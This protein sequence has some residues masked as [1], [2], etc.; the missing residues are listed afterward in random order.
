MISYLKQLQPKV[1][2]SFCIGIFVLI[3]ITIIS[4]LTFV[5]PKVVSASPAKD[6]ADVQLA[7]KIEIKFNL[8]ISRTSITP[9]I[10]PDVEGSWQYT[11][12]ILE[13]HLFNTLVF[14]PTAHFNPATKYT[15]TIGNISPVYG[16]KDRSYS[17]DFT[18][19]TVPVIAATSIVNNSENI[20]IDTPIT[21]DLSEANSGLVD[22]EFSIEPPIEFSVIK[23]EKGYTIKPAS[24]LAAKTIYKLTAM[25]IYNISGVTD[26]GEKDFELNFKTAAAK[27]TTVSAPKPV[28]IAV[29]ATSP[30]N[31][32]S[33][34][35]INSATSVLFN[36]A[37]NRDSA[38][39]HFSIDPTVPGDFSWQNNKMIFTP[40]T[41]F[42]KNYKYKIAVSTGVEGPSGLSSTKSY[43]ATF[44]TEESSII[45]NI[46][47]DYQDKPLSC[48]AAALKMALNFKGAGVSESDI[49]G[50]IG[51]DPTIRNKSIWGDP[52]VAFV[53]D[54]NGHQNSTG[55]GVY[56]GP[57]A[58][59]A[60][61][62]R[63]AKAFSGYSVQNLASE[64]ANGNPVVIWGVAG[65]APYQDDWQTPEGKSIHA[66]KGEHARTAIGFKG[67]VANPASF[68][69]N[70][71]IAGK[72][73]WTAEQL[74]SNW[75]TFGNSGVIVY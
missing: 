49:M 67:D 61:N 2:I 5:T 21:L 53:G 18:T 27:I 20:A 71:P 54:I 6:K 59:A 46:G 39:N 8:P 17:F 33:G 48:E 25:R 13:S 47:L 70:D 24:P 62:W 10:S 56:W 30:K 57:I 22:Y 65:K 15:V 69:I 3:I 52:N 19:Q 14:Q 26:K 63:T 68:I 60:N 32:A 58:K 66:W 16:K 37:V 1:I 38:Q 42:V 51:F 11:G 9:S 41:P 29:S 50:I 73:T 55:Y 36:Q 23:G 64:I 75:S 34:V 12:N 28:S 44:W 72:I 74:K 7:D 43:N 45:L 31:N 4:F 35:S 40:S